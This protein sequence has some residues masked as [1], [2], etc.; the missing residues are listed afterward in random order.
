MEGDM[1]VVNPTLAKE[2]L[3]RGLKGSIENQAKY[4]I[5]K[6]YE[7][8]TTAQKIAA[9]YRQP[10]KIPNK[11]NYI[12]LLKDFRGEFEKQ[13]QGFL[14]QETT[15]ATS[16]INT[17]S[18][19][20]GNTISATNAL[21]LR[22][23][24]DSMRNTSSFRMNANLSMKQG[25]YKN[26]ANLLR[27]TLAKEVPGMA[28]TMNDYRF[29]IEAI[30]SLVTEAVKRNNRQLIGSMDTLL[31]AGGLAMGQ[32]AIGVGL[33]TARKMATTPTAL[34][35]GA[36]ALQKGVINPM[37]A[38]G[39]YVSPLMQAAQPATTPLKYNVLSEIQKRLQGQY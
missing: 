34:T 36:Q 37:E 23:F 24:L 21:D 9:T 8:E 6:T 28:P 3:D 5:G 33:V 38:V 35:Y 13:G 7:L 16:L 27:T 29:Y 12:N 11:Q 30:D 17:L 26:A 39:G 31:G 25:A 15:K 10:L 14:G 2:A 19:T 18:K 32:P 20:K 1:P 22:R 4:S